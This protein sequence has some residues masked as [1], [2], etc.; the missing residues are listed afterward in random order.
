M[1]YLHGL[2]ITGRLGEFSAYKRWDSDKIIFRR[3]GGGSKEK[4][5]TSKTCVRTR[6]NMK[7][8]GARAKMASWVRRAMWPQRLLADY[9]FIGSINPLVR[10]VQELDTQGKIGRRAI[11]LSTD[12][13]ILEGFSLNEKT[14]FDMIVQTSVHGQIIRHTRTATIALPELLPGINFTPRVNHPLFCIQAAIGLVPDI[15]FEE[16]HNR[17]E[18]V[19]WCRELRLDTLCTPWYPT[20]KGAPASTLELD[21]K[22]L[23]PAEDYTLVL[24]IG[25]CFGQPGRREDVEQV[26][27]AGAAKILATA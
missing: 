12:P 4:I 14:T 22:F 8:F 27:R 25:I 1:A 16:K 3:K 15:V 7:E 19:A 2:P 5:M 17:Y 24:S 23:P 11:R 6:E 18:P 9:N 20:I 13:R 26:V 21:L 10:P